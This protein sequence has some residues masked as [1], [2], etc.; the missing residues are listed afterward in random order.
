MI[1]LSPL[2]ERGYERGFGMDAPA[3]SRLH[4]GRVRI[5]LNFLLIL[6]GI[7]ERVR[8]TMPFSVHTQDTMLSIQHIKYV[9]PASRNVCHAF[10]SWYFWT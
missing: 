3:V 2:H 7:P 1:S 4:V 6:W 9:P 5:V 8:E 10:L